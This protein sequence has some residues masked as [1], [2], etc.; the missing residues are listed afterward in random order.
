MAGLL[1]GLA[2]FGLSALEGMDLYEK[3]KEQEKADTAQE[4]K[5]APVAEEQDFLFSKSYECPICSKQFKVRTV[6]AGR[7]R[8]LGSDVDLR[9]RYE[10]VDVLK[11]DV[12]LCPRCGYAALS[13]VFEFIAAD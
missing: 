1:S 2:R 6:K 4:S 9:P 7:A 12:I 3:P 13:W 11:Y 10:N 8:L 5:K